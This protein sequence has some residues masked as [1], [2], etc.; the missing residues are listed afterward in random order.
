VSQSRELAEQGRCVSPAREKAKSGGYRVVTFYSGPD[1]PVFLLNVFAKNEKTDLTPKERHLL[2]AILLNIV[3]V[4]RGK[5][6][7]Q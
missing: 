4:Y 1:I 2:K 5:G 3:D 7:K 6:K